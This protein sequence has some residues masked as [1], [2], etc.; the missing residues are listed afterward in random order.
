M[1]SRHHGGHASVFSA[2]TPNPGHHGTSPWVESVGAHHVSRWAGDHGFPTE[3]AA[4]ATGPRP[5][6]DRAAARAAQR[7]AIIERHEAS[8]RT[9]RDESEDK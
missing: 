6:R 7:R 3:E 9:G 8:R 5:I 1:L 2:F 4:E